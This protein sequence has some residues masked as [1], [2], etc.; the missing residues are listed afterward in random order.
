MS[1]PGKKDSLAPPLMYAF[2]D[3]FDEK[4]ARKRIE[5]RV[6][7]E[8][9]VSRRSAL[10]RRGT[11]ETLLKRNLVF[12]LLSLV[13]TIDLGSAI[14][15]SDFDY[16]K[17]SILNYGLPDLARLTSEEFEVDQIAGDLRRAL[18]QHEPRL[19]PETLRI[20]RNDDF[21]DLNQRIRFNV[22]AEMACRPVDVPIEFVAEIE[23][24]SGKVVLSR[25]PVAP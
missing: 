21:D 16:V 11:D 18:L 14:D 3:A 24:A 1:N 15:I 9:R 7:G 25:L 8:R 10:S 17:R 13:N 2:R 4:D 20:E 12:D 22:S 6:N 5:E 19:I 23:I